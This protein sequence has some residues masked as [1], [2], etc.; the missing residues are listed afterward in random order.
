L[1]Q[2]R[3]TGNDLGKDRVKDT[4]NYPPAIPD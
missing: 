1:F 4:G 3:V 2:Q